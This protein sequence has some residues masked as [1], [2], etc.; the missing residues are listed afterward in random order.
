M[1]ASSGTGIT[2]L[3]RAWGAGNRGALESLM[4]L[5]HKQL[6]ATAHRY[7]VR[8]K[9]GHLLQSAA[10]INETYLRLLQVKELEWQDRGHFYAI[11]ARLMREVLTDYARA[12]L[13]TKRGGKKRRVAIED[14]GDIGGGDPDAE[15]IELDYLLRELSEFDERMG[16]IVQYR[17]F[18]GTSV[19]E[20][21]AAL[22]ISERTVKREWQ[23]AK[24]WLSRELY[25]R[26][27][28]G[29]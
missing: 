27:Q 8:Q 29:P 21:A 17:A 26:K 6:Q 14:A 2:V 15:L 10:L 23:I 20:T 22:G 13:S 24:T 7:M 11:C 19:E 18:V 4:P 16:K 28:S 3:L 12:E 25:R 5:V 1:E 9:P